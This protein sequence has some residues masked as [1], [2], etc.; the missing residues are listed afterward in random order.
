MNHASFYIMM[1][2]PYYHMDN[3]LLNYMFFPPEF[4]MPVK[5][6]QV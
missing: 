1:I 5:E 2:I 4:G 3:Y 6:N